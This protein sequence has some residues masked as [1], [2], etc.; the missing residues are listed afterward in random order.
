MD[1][2][3]RKEIDETFKKYFD[4]LKSGPRRMAK[5]YKGVLLAKGVWK[6]TGID[7][8]EDRDI[9]EGKK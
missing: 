8:P 2:K 1:E 7:L 3:T 9:I 5:M 6:Y 4:A